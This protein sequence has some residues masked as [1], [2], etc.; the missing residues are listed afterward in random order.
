[1]VPGTGR[2][3]TIKNDE[4]L[5]DPD[6]GSMRNRNT[7]LFSD[8]QR[9]TVV[10]RSMGSRCSMNAPLL[11][12]RFRIGSSN[13]SSSRQVFRMIKTSTLYCII[14]NVW[15]EG[16]WPL[17]TF[18]YLKIVKQTFNFFNSEQAR[19][20]KRLH[21]VRKLNLVFPSLSVVQG[22]FTLSM[23]EHM[24]FHIFFVSLKINLFW[25]KY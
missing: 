24:Q 12:M 18:S 7:S 14:C 9:R 25:W 20:Q 13:Y 10:Y 1:M 16:S 3:Y 6:L 21:N 23:C 19:G 11:W 22:L 17:T 4:M 2:L 15:S 8:N 5:T